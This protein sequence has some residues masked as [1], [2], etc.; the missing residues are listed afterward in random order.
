MAI[1]RITIDIAPESLGMSDS[2]KLND[3]LNVIAQLARKGVVIVTNKRVCAAERGNGLSPQ[4]Q[5]TLD[6]LT[7][8]H[9][10][11]TFTVAEIALGLGIEEPRVR[12]VMHMLLT[13]G[14]VHRYP[15]YRLGGITGWALVDGNHE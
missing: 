1:R 12:T 6:Y 11:E 15:N 5:A 9:L 10:R 3:A 8:H 4:V 2:K 7:T 13:K 14:L